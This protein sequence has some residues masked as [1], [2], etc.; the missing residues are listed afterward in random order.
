[1]KPHR[2]SAGL[3]LLLSTLVLSAQEMFITQV[4]RSSQGRFVV[5]HQS[6]PAYYYILYRG[7]NVA[8]I[9]SAVDMALGVPVEGELGDAPDSAMAAFYRVL[10]VPV[11][12]PLDTDTDGIDDVWELRFRRPRAALNPNDANEDH[13]GSGFPDLQDYQLPVAYFSQASNTVF[14]VNSNLAFVTVQFSKS[15][16]NPATAILLVGGT[17]VFQEDFLI[18]GFVASNQT[19]RIPVVGQT[20][21]FAVTLLDAA[22]IDPDRYLVLSI[23]EPSTNAPARYQTS[24]H[25]PVNH[26]L[27]VTEGDLGLYA[28]LLEFTNQLGSGSHPVRLAL[29]SAGGGQANGYL[30]LTQSPFFQ[31]AV[32]LPVSISLAGLPL[33]FPQPVVFQTNA[34]VLGKS[35]TWNL[36]FGSVVATTNATYEVPATLSLSGL[37]ASGQAVTTQGLM[38]LIQVSPAE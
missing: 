9:V 35:L 17:A 23:L 13:T 30:D 20:A 29:R 21:T 16:T 24:Q 5:R 3:L 12:N 37:S 38:R 10:Q 1:M 19:A 28:G 34:A 36:Q 14:A 27:R 7:T 31:R 18:N 33:S 15:F 6:D 32:S 11:V 22:S 8:N 26:T 4:T 2:F 25:A